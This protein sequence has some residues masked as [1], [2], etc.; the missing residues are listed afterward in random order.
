MKDMRICFSIQDNGVGM[1]EQQLA[2]LWE[3]DYSTKEFGHGIGMQAIKRI[4]DE[5]GAQIEVRSEVGN[6]TEFIVSFP[7]ML[8]MDEEK[9]TDVADELNLR[10]AANTK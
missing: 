6:G 7:A 4:A 5:H 8:I 1:S 3:Q 9:P 10:R 2:T